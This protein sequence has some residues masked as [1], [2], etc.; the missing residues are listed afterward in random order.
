MG[1]NPTPMPGPVVAEATVK[2]APTVGGALIAWLC[3]V[4]LFSALALAGPFFAPLGHS[5]KLDTAASFGKGELLGFGLAVFAAALSRWIV[6]DARS[7]VV[8]QSLSGAGL[9]LVAI[10]IAL[11]W[12][13]AYQVQIG[14]SKA[15]FFPA[16][17]VV[18]ASWVLVGMAL[19][20]G[21]ATE[22]VYVL[23]LR[24]PA[25]KVGE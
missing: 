13:D 17:R 4:V 9:V 10:A 2:K 12:V 23:G 16:A 25:V 22:I 15:L 3:T 6:H 20:C 5:G 8:L 7:N 14:D 11:V 18:L 19:L 1:I 24:P 21:A